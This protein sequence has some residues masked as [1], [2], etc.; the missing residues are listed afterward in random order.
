MTKANYTDIHVI[1]DRSGSMKVIAQDTIGGFNTF[2]EEQ[3]KLDV[4]TC[5]LSLHQFDDIYQTDYLCKNI[6]NVDLLT[7]STFVRGWTALNDAIGRTIV[8]MGNRYRNMEEYERPSKVIVLIMT[9]GQENASEKYADGSLIRDMIKEQTSKYNWEFVY[10]GANQDA[11]GTAHNYG[12]AAS[13][14]LNM[15]YIIRV[16]KKHI[17]LSLPM[18]LMSVAVPMLQ[19]HFLTT[20]LRHNLMQD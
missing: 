17:V 6:K 13:N 16:L 18:Y 2:V 14:A 19:C 9:D 11:I 15:A 4:G 7:E 8:E 5:T 10:I 20:M 12:I 1:L 3:Q